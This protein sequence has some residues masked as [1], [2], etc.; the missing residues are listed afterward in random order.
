MNYCWEV[1]KKSECE[2]CRFFSAF[3]AGTLDV[4]KMKGIIMVDEEVAGTKI[5]A[6]TQN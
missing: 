6:E 2:T 5:P 3:Q 4:E 1:Y